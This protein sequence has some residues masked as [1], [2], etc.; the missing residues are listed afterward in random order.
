MHRVAVERRYGEPSDEKDLSSILPVGTRYHGR[1]L[2]RVVYRVHGGILELEYVDGDVKSI[3]TT[4]AYYRTANG[5]GPATQL[6]PDR[7]IRLHELGDVGPPGCKA[8][9][10]G[11]SFDGEC[12]DAWLTS[13]RA[14]TMTLLYV[15]RGRRIENVRVGDP[16][17]I[18]PCF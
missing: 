11:F 13:L 16:D 2:V 1:R 3:E 18:L 4:S 7:C 17:V 12:L 6:P 10:R 8:T 9:W 5:I 15:H 14:R